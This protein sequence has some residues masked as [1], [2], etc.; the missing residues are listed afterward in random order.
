VS[1]ERELLTRAEF[2]EY[3]RVGEWKGKQILNQHPELVIR[4]GDRVLIPIASA[5]AYVHQLAEAQR[6]LA[7]V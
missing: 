1:V 4:I 7:A 5:R 2:F 3:L 6:E